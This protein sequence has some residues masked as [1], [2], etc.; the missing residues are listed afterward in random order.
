MTNHIT[1]NDPE[2]S[3]RRHRRHDSYYLNYRSSTSREGNAPAAC[4]DVYVYIPVA[5][6]LLL[7]LVYLVECWHCHTRIQLQHK[8]DVHTVYERIAQM[9]E[10]TPVLWWKALCYH[11]VRKSRQITR[12]RSGDTVTYTQHY[13]DKVIT[14]SARGSFDYSSCGVKDVSR[15]LI[16]IEK[17]AAVKLKFSKGFSFVSQRS[18]S[19]FDNQRNR[20]FSENQLFDVY[21]ETQ[22]GLELSNTCFNRY[23]IC[24]CDP[25][26]LPWYLSQLTFWIFS[27]TLLSWPLRVLIEYKTAHVQY[28]IHKLFGVNHLLAPAAP[29]ITA[30]P[31]EAAE[32]RISRD[33]TLTSLEL[34]LK[35]RENFYQLPSYSEAILMDD[36][37]PATASRHFALNLDNVDPPTSSRDPSPPCSSEN[38]PLL[39]HNT[40]PQSRNGSTHNRNF[41][42]SRSLHTVHRKPPVRTSLTS[43]GF[44]S[45][46]FRRHSSSVNEREVRQSSSVNN[47]VYARDFRDRSE[48]IRDVLS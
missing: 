1:P 39:P 37:L 33:V 21:M 9:R 42:S 43:L 4:K 29:E 2:N 47:D 17:Y 22:E 48:L 24:F 27:L 30:N 19:D 28:H 16:D 18:E 3:P 11:F 36:E 23:I 38:Q 35:I 41:P 46:H 34:D 25:N 20:F 15:R 31:L 13:Q 26:N 12:Y 8:I 14:H 32:E 6:M 45:G 5:F 7:Y 40:N 10:A 44:T